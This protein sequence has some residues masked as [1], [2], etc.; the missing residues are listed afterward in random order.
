MALQSS[1]PHNSSDDGYNSVAKDVDSDL[2]QDCDSCIM[3]CEQCE[4]PQMKGPG[5]FIF[6]DMICPV[7]IYKA[8]DVNLEFL[9]KFT[10][11]GERMKE[12]LNAR[13]SLNSKPKSIPTIRDDTIPLYTPDFEFYSQ[14]VPKLIST[15]PEK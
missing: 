4:K 15:V 10:K 12:V 2:D 14:I 5:G 1:P 8:S 7:G 3:I 11:F 6:G 9:G 13:G